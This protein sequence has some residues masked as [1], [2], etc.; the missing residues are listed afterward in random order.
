MFEMLN[1]FIRIP[2]YEFVKK[3]LQITKKGP[4]NLKLT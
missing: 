4:K 3:Y 2:L 1:K